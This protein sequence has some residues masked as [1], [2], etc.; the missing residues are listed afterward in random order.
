[1][2]GVTRPANAEDVVRLWPAVKA[3]RLMHS[4]EELGRYRAAAPWRVRVSDAGEA[5]VLST[6][7]AHLATLAI[8]GLWAAPQRVGA[9][10]DDAAAIARSQ[11]YSEVLSP[12]VAYAELDPYVAAGMRPIEPIVA[13]QGHAEAI[14]S[15]DPPRAEETAVRVGHFWEIDKLVEVDDACFDEFWRYGESEIEDSMR[16]ER[17][18]VAERDGAIV[19]YCTCSLHGA[20]ATIGRLAVAP[21][22]RRQGVGALLLTDAA[23]YASRCRAE[24]VTL[25]TQEANESS[26]SLYLRCAL[27]ELPERYA[28]ALRPA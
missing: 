13:L 20:T 8:R 4:S 16:R 25:C 24:T 18:T 17:L 5:L 15:A 1:M 7:R 19:G 27:V 14:V 21:H 26:R 22:A 9:L 6:W 12:L 28:L 2:S 10:I 11:G 3:S 23:A